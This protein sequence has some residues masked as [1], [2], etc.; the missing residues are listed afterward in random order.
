MTRHLKIAIP[1]IVVCLIFSVFIWAQ[2]DPQSEHVH[3]SVPDSQLPASVINR[4]PPSVAD[5]VTN[6]P[7]FSLRDGMSSTLMM[8]NTQVSSITA[9]VTVYNM[10]GDALP[11]DPIV[12]GHDSVVELDLASLIKDDRF[13]EGNIQVAYRGIN[14]AVSAHT[15]VSSK[16]NRVSFESPVQEMMQFHA[17]STKL[18]GVL[19]LPDAQAQGFL[20]ITNAS[21]NT[22][23]VQLGV[24]SRQQEIQLYPRQTRVVDFG[25]DFGQSTAGATI[26]GLQHTGVP[27][28]II[29]TGFVLNL[30]NGYSSGF[31]MFDSLLQ[32]STHLAGAHFWFGQADSKKGFREGARFHSPLLLANVSASPVTAH[33]SLDYTVE[34][35]SQTE[36][37][38]PADA[39]PAARKNSKTPSPKVSTMHVNDVLIAPGEVKQIEL[40]DPLAAR[41]SAD[42]IQDNGVDIDYDGPPG[43]L[44]GFLASVDQSGDYSFEV[45]IQDAAAMNTTQGGDYPWSLEQGADTIL[46]LKNTTDK[47]TSALVQFLFPDGQTYTPER[48][49]L[50]PY[51]T[52]AIDIQDLKDSKKL[53]VQGRSFPSDATNGALF[54]VQ[55]IPHTMIGRA[56]QVNAQAGTAR[57]YNCHYAPNCCESPA[58]THMSPDSGTFAV[59]WTGYGFEPLEDFSDGCGHYVFG[60]P[61]SGPSYTSDNSTA[62]SVDS[63]DGELTCN[64]AGSATITASWPDYI[65]YDSGEDGCG[66]FWSTSYASAQGYV[67]A[68]SCSPSSA[69]RGDTVTCTV[70]NYA[71]GSSFS[72]WTFTDSGTAT[73]TR[74]VNSS[75]W[76][77]T[78]VTSGTVGVTVNGPNGSSTPTATVTVTNRNFH[79]S[80]ASPTSVANGTF[81]NLPVPPSATGQDSGLGY[82]GWHY[83]LGSNSYSTISDGGPNQGY[84]YWPS[85]ISFSTWNFQYE[86]NP[87]LVNSS[88][89]FSQEQWG[90]CGF[91][92]WSNLFAQTERH[93]YNS[94]TESHY[95]FYSNSLDSNNPGDYFESDTALPGANLS[96]FATSAT[97]R[98]ITLLGTVSTASDVE[99]YPVNYSE[100]DTFLGNINYATYT[101]CP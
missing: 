57:S 99:P 52:V 73:V 46:H 15:T 93:E 18:N 86:I 66:G 96:T 82:F 1:L 98:I 84:T 30:K 97:N 74:N 31:A 28:D 3:G 35:K 67:P 80:A 14:M 63:G 95:A 68:L 49:F 11:L 40:A 75:T 45:P 70:T 6:I 77:G 8:N 69:T 76:S 100:T 32:T 12:L 4:V 81:Y 44:I 38:Q 101:P 48:R 62:I 55:L 47:E 17:M 21:H 36:Q 60:E 25:K 51:Q 85:N 79:T 54:W 42:P 7:Y 91:I 56:E 78:M 58:G 53:D 20:A 89:T 92:S 9:T 65:S 27:G 26:V 71:P 61:A 2:A 87:D 88:S 10:Q 5:R 50:Q 94:S 22:D 24:G 39:K 41:A 64:A 72:N 90:A 83:T 37:A 23:T 19:W 43:S 59:G 29:T 16:E 13:L 34:D 33:V